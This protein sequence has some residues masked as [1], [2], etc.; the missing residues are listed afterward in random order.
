M[1]IDVYFQGQPG[2]RLDADCH[3]IIEQHG[4]KVV[5]SGT[6]LPTMSRDVQADIPEDRSRACVELLRN[7]GFRVE[8]R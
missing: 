4:G 5:A 1:I 8:P 2:D 6:F 7:K 3:D